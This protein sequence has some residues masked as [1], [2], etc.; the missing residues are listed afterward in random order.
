MR[1]IRLRGKDFN[2]NDPSTSHMMPGWES[3]IED[4]F[5][6]F[7]PTYYSVGNTKT[8]GSK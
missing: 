2:P 5:A 7:D 3:F 4:G 8:Q 6:T 1:E